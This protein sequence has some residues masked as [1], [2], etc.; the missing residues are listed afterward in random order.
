MKKTI[1]ILLALVLA[2]PSALSAEPQEDLRGKVVRISGAVS[3]VGVVLLYKAGSFIMLDEVDGSK[4]QKLNLKDQDYQLD[5]LADSREAYLQM[6]S[7][8]L[9]PAEI[10]ARD[11]PAQ[12]VSAYSHLPAI[13]GNG[14]KSRAGFSLGIG[15]GNLLS[16]W[17]FENNGYRRVE[18]SDYNFELQGVFDF[19]FTRIGI[20]TGIISSRFHWSS[21][22]YGTE[23]SGRNNYLTFMV[24]FCLLPIR[25]FAPNSSFQ[26]Y[27]GGTIGNNEIDELLSDG[28][29]EFTYGSPL[30]GFGLGPKFG[31]E[32]YLGNSV[33]LF[34]EGNY[35]YIPDSHSESRSYFNALIG[36]RYRFPFE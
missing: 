33:V 3:G 28:V 19:A 11:K 27:L 18:R 35:V 12:A 20:S 26:L 10:A 24:N 2:G 7:N 25:F 1:V 4:Q 23:R 21:E 32:Y 5:I 29:Y 13:I 31:M 6:L 36:I 34:S 8:G 16:A 30:R 15:A 14:R 9:T 17:T 22:K